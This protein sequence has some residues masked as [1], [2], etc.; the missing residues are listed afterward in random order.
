MFKKAWQMK[1][2]L[3]I[4]PPFLFTGI[5]V[6]D[7]SEDFRQ[8]KVRLKLNMF[9]QNAVGVHFGGSLYAMTDPFCMLLVMAR[10][11]KDYIVWDKSADIDYIK[12]GKGTVT[13]EFVITDALI[14][15]ILTHTAQG[16]KY[17]PEIPV[18]VKDAQ[19]EIVA[20]LNRKLY[21]RRKKS[22]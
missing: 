18:Y 1:L 4:W 22:A 12:P 13:A 7:V 11:G 14:A 17:L 21:I 19:G 2:L 3:N 10:L 6:V 15:D 9:N 8:A 5:R 16:E 20:K